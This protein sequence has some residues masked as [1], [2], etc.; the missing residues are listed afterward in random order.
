[1]YEILVLDDAESDLERLD[2]LLARR[3]VRRVEWLA[4]HLDEIKLASLTGEFSGLF[5]LR[6]GDYRVIYRVIKSENLIVIH[7]IGH[8]RDLYR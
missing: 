2:R 4:E 5:K 3:I 6:V 7:R 1:M 8:R